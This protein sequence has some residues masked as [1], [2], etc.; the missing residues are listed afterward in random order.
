ML[1]QC[2]LV[3]KEYVKTNK[4]QIEANSKEFGSEI[5]TVDFNQ[6]KEGLSSFARRTVGEAL[7]G[8]LEA[9][10]QRSSVEPNGTSVTKSV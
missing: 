1:H 5:V 6:L 2:I 10:E 7:N 8:L 3:Y 4:D 9:E